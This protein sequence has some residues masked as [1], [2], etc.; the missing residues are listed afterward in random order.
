MKITSLRTVALA[1]IAVTM[2][3]IGSKQ[4][5]ATTYV[6][7]RVGTPP[8]PPPTVVYR[9]WPSPYRGA[10]WIPGHQEWI[11][12]RWVWIGGYYSYPPRH[13]G[14]WV[15]ARYRNGYYYPG[16]WAY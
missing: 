4:A 8:P 13:G 15:S 12:G 9:Q 16:H 14:Y 1:L 11:N 7:V 10:V 6:S 2:L 5:S 3:F